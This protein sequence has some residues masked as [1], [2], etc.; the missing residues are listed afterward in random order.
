MVAW[1]VNLKELFL[2]FAVVAVALGWW[3]DRRCLLSQ[4][5][6]Q[7]SQL[8]ELR[9][10]LRGLRLLVRV[11]PQPEIDDVIHFLDSRTELR[12]E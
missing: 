5:N 12:E 11:N 4:M 8:E 3:V 1:R 9:S 6:L 10:T 2:L 7:Q